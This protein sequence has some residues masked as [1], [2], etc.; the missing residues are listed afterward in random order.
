MYIIYVL[1]HIVYSH[2][3]MYIIY[4]LTHIRVYSHID[5]C[6]HTYSI[7]PYIYISIYIY[8]LTHIHIVYSHTCPLTAREG[9]VYAA[10]IPSAAGGGD[11][12]PQAGQGAGRRCPEGE[13][14]Q[15]TGTAATGQR[16]QHGI[17]GPGGHVHE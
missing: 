4:V 5:T 3:Y 15:H 6:P 12:P 8:V 14:R 1:T 13:G 11:D 7:F 10:D 2:I 17:Q 16:V 9:E